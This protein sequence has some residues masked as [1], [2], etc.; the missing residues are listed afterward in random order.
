M[1]IAYFDLGFSLEDYAI[2]NTKKYGGGAV[3]ARYLKQL[4]GLNDLFFHC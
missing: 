2:T 1:K 3:V 4:N